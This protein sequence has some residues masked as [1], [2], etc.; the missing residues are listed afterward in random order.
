MRVEKR[1]VNR[2]VLVAAIAALILAGPAWAA[3]PKKGPLKVFLL[4]GQSN[5]EGHDEL[6]TIDFLGEDPDNDR[7]ALLKKFKPD[8]KTLVT[9][10]DV[11][12]V[13]NG[14]VFDKLQPGL[15]ARRDSATL[16]NKIGP[17]Y[18]F[19]YFMGEALDEQVLLIKY[20][21]G[22]QSLYQNFRPPSAGLPE[23]LPPKTKPE[24]FGNQYRALIGCRT[25]LWVNFNRTSW[26]WL[27]SAERFR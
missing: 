13:S 16:G 7:A 10:D 11:W 8:G 23:P 18:A 17:E 21:V 2:S 26:P 15:G 4:A 1:F 25:S 20:A 12:V 24:D 3:Q 6:R 19:G 5:M 9:R 22:G 14:A 27:D